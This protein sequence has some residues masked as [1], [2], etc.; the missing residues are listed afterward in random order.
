MHRSSST[1]ILAVKLLL[2]LVL[3]VLLTSCNQSNPGRTSTIQKDASQVQA[4]HVHQAGNPTGL[5]TPT[6][7]GG[8]IASTG[9][10]AIPVNASIGQL[11]NPNAPLEMKLLIISA[12]KDDSG[13]KTAEALMKQVGVPYDILIAKDKTLTSDML[14]NGNQGRYQGIILTTASLPYQKDDGSFASAFEPAEWQTLWSYESDLA[15]RQLTLYTFPSVYPEDYGIKGIDNNGD[16]WADGNNNSFAMTMTPEGQTIFSSLKANASIPVK[17]AFNY[18]SEL[19]ASGGISATPILKDATGNILGVVSTS[20][21]GRER[22]ALTMGHNP[23]L[24]HTQLLGYDMLRW[25]TQGVFIGERRMYLSLDIDDWYLESDV[26][27]PATLSNFPYEEK[28]YRIDAQDVYAARDGVL[29]LRTRFN[30][31]TFNYIQVFNALKGDTNASVDC[32]ETASLSA[33]SLC[34]GTFFDW[35]SHTFSHAEMD[36]LTYDD[37]RAEFEQNIN[38]GES[39]AIDFDR[40]FVVTGKHSGLGWHRIQDAPGITCEVDQVPSDEFCQFG[41]QASNKAMLRAAA[42]LGIKYMAA[43]RGWDSHTRADGC[44]TCLIRHPIEDRISLVPRWPT[45][46]FYNTTDPIENASEFNNLYGPNGI[47]RDGFGNPFFT[48][49]RTWEQVLNFEAEIAMRHVLS[50][51]PYPHFFHQNN[52]REYAPGRSLM[53]DWSEAVLKE[54]SKYFDVPIISQDWQGMTETLEQRTSFYTALKKGAIRGTWNRADNSV[55][56]TTVIPT[57]IFVTGVDLNN[58]KTWR[59]G[60]DKVSQT[61]LTQEGSANG[62]VAST[63]SISANRAPTLSGISNQTSAEGAATSIALNFN[64]ADNDI[65]GFSATNLP[66][67]LAIDPATGKIS[68]TAAFGTEGTYTVNVVLSDGQTKARQSFIWTIV[69]PSP[70]GVFTADF[71]S[72]R[73][74]FVYKDN[75]FRNTSEERYARGDRDS[76]G[77]YLFTVVGGID[78]ETITGISGGF[79]RNFTLNQTSNVT[80]SLRYRI[81]QRLEY[82]EDEFIQALLSINGQLYGLNNGD[83]LEQMAGGG[84]SDW[85]TVS[86]EIGTLAAGTHSI[87]VGAYNNQKNSDN[88][89]AKVSFDDIKVE[90]VADGGTPI[91]TPTGPNLAGTWTGF[92]ACAGCGSQ[93]IQISQ[94][95]NDIVATKITGDSYVPAGEVTWTAN[96]ATNVGEG[97]IADLGYSNRRLV[98]GTLSVIDEKTIRFTWDGFSTITFYRD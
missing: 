66:P 13:L 79:E 90:A 51:S 88:E 1:V 57:T 60:V 95:G 21:D 71:E 31:P 38:F 35:V 36:F 29:D 74:D 17:H 12:T 45:N 16:G 32:S 91:V 19:D 9:D 55:N 98:P 56:I 2:G 96:V 6:T 52:L 34:T 64:D 39:Q 87:Q 53:Y 58:G 47:I 30:A 14:M 43:N 89:S 44:D 75:L 92:Y 68:G 23:F 3:F 11:A 76:V 77:K 78:D 59:Y 26:W 86:L 80:V 94:S 27:N 50:F 70:N 72:S 15:V 73:E 7:A 84:D 10:V 67:G 20:A 41:L 42:D 97:V 24:L 65:V 54:Y 22:M 62:A 40:A 18:P 37:A 82:E 63:A 83:H 61:Y 33:A 5:N 28:V 81:E 25:L 4:S 46:I 49:D 69:P 8:E 48:T 85:K 93:A